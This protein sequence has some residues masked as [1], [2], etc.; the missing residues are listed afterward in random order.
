MKKHD[1]FARV[2]ETRIRKGD[3]FLREFPTEH[4]LAAESGTSRMTTRR[5]LS[6]LMDKGLLVRKPHGRVSV[7]NDH[8]T[9]TGRVRL[10]FLAPA[11]GSYYYD[12]WRHHVDLAAARSG[13]AVR[14]VD[15]VHWDD[16]VIPQTLSAFDGV[17]LAVSSEPIPDATLKLLQ[18][19]KK[20]VV[21]D[22]DFSAH[23][24]PSIELFPPAAI[25]K[26]GNHLLSLGHRHIDCLNT[27][28]HDAVIRQRLDHWAMWQ[29]LNKVQGELLESPVQPY[30][31][32]ALRAYEVMKRR[33]AEGTWEAT[34][35]LALT[36]TAATGAIR[37]LHE[38]GYRVGKDISVCAVEGAGEARLHVPSRTVLEPL[39]PSP[40]V[41][42]CIDWMGKRNEPW[43][44]PLLLQP[45]SVPL[46]EGESTGPAPGRRAR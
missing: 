35:L 23:G 25:G 39:D 22:S 26:L 8:E 34:A 41:A 3:Y 10:A 4:Q 19:T 13:T 40:Y 46:F 42:M 31:Q 16:P 15:Y 18:R 27:Q 12:T 2:L 37:A 36:N 7:N 32:A 14:T 24:V 5:A 44:G 30:E 11:W 1:Q 20:L 45:P 38:H 17:F 29:Q 21:V 28:P 43:T 6:A 9:V 33:L